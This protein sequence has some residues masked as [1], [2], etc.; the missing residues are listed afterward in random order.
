[1]THSELSFMLRLVYCCHK[2]LQMVVE[3]PCFLAYIYQ[4]RKFQLRQGLINP[5]LN[6]LDLG[7]TTLYVRRM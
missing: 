1:M 5:Y 4:E 6:F 3:A 2:C 7:H